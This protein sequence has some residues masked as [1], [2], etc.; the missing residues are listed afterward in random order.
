MVAERGT[1]TEQAG[2]RQTRRALFRS[3]RGLVERLI[4]GPQPEPEE[5]GAG[6]R[7]ALRLE[8]EASGTVGA[9]VDAALGAL[10]VEISGQLTIGAGSLLGYGSDE[11]KRLFLPLIASGQAMA[12]ALTEVGVGVNAKRIQAYVETDA[13]GDYRLFA[14]GSCNK[15]WITNARHGGLLGVVARIVRGG[16][17]IGL[18]VLELPADDVGADAGYEFRCEPSGV[19]AFTACHHAAVFDASHHEVAAVQARTPGTTESLPVDSAYKRPL[20]QQRIP[21]GR[22]KSRG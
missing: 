5:L 22:L 19:A 16:D 2:E 3:Q 21:C 1:R 14:E 6:A 4:Y 18:F 13:S 15:L 12:F 17:R 20:C 11:Q 9:V 8:S 7:E 10:A